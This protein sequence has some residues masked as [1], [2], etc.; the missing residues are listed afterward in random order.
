MSLCADKRE[1]ALKTAPTRQRSTFS[2]SRI[3]LVKTEHPLPQSPS[4]AS[5]HPRI[6]LVED[7]TTIRMLVRQALEQ[8]GFI[9]EEAAN[10]KLA[11]ALFTQTQ[12]DLVLL[13][14]IMPEMDGFQTCAALRDTVQGKYLPIVM[15]TGLEDEASINR[16]YEVGATD[17]ITKPI[18]WVLLGHR[19][20][21]LLRASRAMRQVQQNEEAFRQEVHLST[22]LVQ[23]GRD[24]TSSL[25][26]PIILERLCQLTTAV[27]DCDRGYTLLYQSEQDIYTVMASYGYA[28]HQQ[29]AFNVLNLSGSTISPFVKQ[30]I[31]AGVISQET[32]EDQENVPEILLEPFTLASGLCLRITNLPRL[33]TSAAAPRPRHRAVRFT[34]AR[35][36]APSRTSGKRD[37][38]QIGISFHRLT[39]TAHANTHYPGVSRFVA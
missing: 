19:I 32:D 20:R 9:V 3:W 18:N 15:L 17:F 23:V 2:E 38:P 5:I 37:T 11:L 7:G 34:R 1:D 30:L 28:P 14:V 24:L 39:R 33:L 8:A 25:A 6:L 31:H 36:R 26:T 22:T 29:D 10:G 16:A 4:S 35:Q 12:P 27:F 21:Y 13:D